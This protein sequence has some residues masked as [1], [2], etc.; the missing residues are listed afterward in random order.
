LD[1]AGLRDALGATQQRHLRVVLSVKRKVVGYA[2]CGASDR[3]GFV[4]RLAVLPEAQGQGI[5]KRL[6]LDGLYWL[7]GLNAQHIVVNTQMGNEAALALYRRVGFR[8]DPAGLSVLAAG[9]SRP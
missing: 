7:R 2:I 6:L 1:R 3:R 9:L 4:Q 8:E 5:G